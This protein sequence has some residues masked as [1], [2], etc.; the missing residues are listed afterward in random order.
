MCIND[1]EGCLC[2][3]GGGINVPQPRT[4]NVNSDLSGAGPIFV[5][6]LKFA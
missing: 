3:V 4:V 6:V 5:D 2:R 1:V